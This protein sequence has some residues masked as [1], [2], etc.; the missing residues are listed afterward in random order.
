MTKADRLLLLWKMLKNV[1]WRMTWN[2]FIH[3]KS[4]DHTSVKARRER[5]GVQGSIF[6]ASLR[7][8]HWRWCTGEQQTLLGFMLCDAEQLLAKCVFFSLELHL[9]SSLVLTTVSWTI[10]VKL[11]SPPATQWGKRLKPW[12]IHIHSGLLRESAVGRLMLWAKL[13]F[14]S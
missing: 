1:F 12:L 3:M 4:K 13:Y 6:I 11:S 10:S 7:G 9:A 5:E 8:Q 14:S 2:S